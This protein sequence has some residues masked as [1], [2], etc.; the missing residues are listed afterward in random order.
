MLRS[1]ALSTANSIHVDSDA[2]F[3][4]CRYLYRL[5]D[6]SERINS[7]DAYFFVGD[8]HCEV[9]WVGEWPR[10]RERLIEQ[11]RSHWV[12]RQMMKYA[13]IT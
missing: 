10:D 5:I 7:S 1:S 13:L 2:A 3:G 4:A 8:G 6:I 9:V 12:C 11:R